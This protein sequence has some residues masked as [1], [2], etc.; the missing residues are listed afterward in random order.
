MPTS[1]PD[2]PAHSGS[3]PFTA[4]AGL[5]TAAASPGTAATVL[6]DKHGSAAVSAVNTINPLA[7][8]KGVHRSCELCARP[9]HSLCPR[10]RLTF[11]CE[12]DHRKLDAT[13]IHEKICPILKRLRSP[14]P[15]LGSEEERKAK[16]LEILDLR[17]KL[18]TITRTDAQKLLFEGE[19]AFAI[20]AALQALRCAMAIYGPHALD[21]VPCYLL[22]GEAS[23]GL[24]QLAQAEE[25]LA[26]AKWALTKQ[27]PGPS[28]NGS[29]TSSTSLATTTWATT[30][31]TSTTT[32][33]IH[34]KLAH[35]YGLLNLA[36]GHARD[37]AAHLA[38]SIAYAAQIH[39]SD[40]IEA[41]GG[42][43]QLGLAFLGA[44]VTGGTVDPERGAVG[45]TTPQAGSINR[46]GAVSAFAR[47][48][49][50][51]ARWWRDRLAERVAVARGGASAGGGM[52]A[53]TELGSTA[54]AGG[55]ARPGSASSTLS[56]VDTPDGYLTPATDP[57]IRWLHGADEA[58]VLDAIL[59]AAGALDS[60]QIA[61]CHVMF[62]R[63]D[64]SF[65]L[66]PRLHVKALLVYTLFSA[67][68]ETLD[69]RKRSITPIGGAGDSVTITS[70]GATLSGAAVERATTAA[71]LVAT[72]Y[73]SPLDDAADVWGAVS[74]AVSKVATPKVRSILPAAAS[75]VVS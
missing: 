31:T 37:A 44:S 23:I 58:T 50:V 42:Y 17:Q 13:A 49:E 14:I 30:Q 64:E 43:F 41:T 74:A 54:A 2:E 56:S 8:P 53:G 34:A 65:S 25:Y 71:Q 45:G 52:V 16:D 19:Y 22:L 33:A 40:A 26:S 24:K 5:V 9:A 21:L 36:R 75:T 47:V 29:G 4:H 15:F 32:L 46:S 18:L 27:G 48:V 67:A 35:N 12:E 51:W 3:T 55:G 59:H 10:C 11:Y 72:G 38:R 20:P 68:T 6:G 28:A 70:A 61:E 63:I 73:L 7:N 69:A 62:T 39:G 1:I 60:A 57:L 66:L